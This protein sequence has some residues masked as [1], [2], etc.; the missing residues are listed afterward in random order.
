MRSY[1]GAPGSGIWT[2]YI[3]KNGILQD[4]TG[5]TADTELVMTGSDIYVARDVSVSIVLA[6]I[7]EFVVNR[8]II[9]AP[10]ALAQI[11][12]SIAFMP[13]DEASFMNTGG[14]NDAFDVTQTNWVW[15]RSEQL[16]LNELECNVPIPLRGVNVTG[17]YCQVTAMPIPGSS[18]T[19]TIRKNGE[20]TSVSFTITYPAVDGQ[21]LGQNVN[22]A[23]G[24]VMT[25]QVEPSS[26]PAPGATG[27]HYWG[28]I[29]LV[30]ESSSGGIYQLVPGKTD[31][32][33]YTGEDSTV[34]VK[35]PDPYFKT[36][37]LGS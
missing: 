37:L 13:D 22:F 3:I 15:V 18:W 21:I 4:G 32:T 10:F 20:D 23:F 1:A 19:Y 12:A 9:N 14:S 28:L 25:L 30:E 36:G 29:S 2:G 33:L 34:D 5:G 6:D 26:S 17:L 31:D 7:L 27:K 8:T 24:D 11:G 35:I 16:V